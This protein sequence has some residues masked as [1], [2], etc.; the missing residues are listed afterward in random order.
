[1]FPHGP[2]VLA[3]FYMAVRGEIYAQATDPEHTITFQFLLTDRATILDRVRS[4]NLNRI[5][6]KHVPFV[7]HGGFLALL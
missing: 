2:Y 3:N 7:D 1:M 4:L 5:V 6:Q